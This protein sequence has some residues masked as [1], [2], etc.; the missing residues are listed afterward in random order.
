MKMRGL[1]ILSLPLLLA[2]F[3]FVV[4]APPANSA[5]NSG[6]VKVEEIITKHLASIGPA[7]SRVSSR[8]RIVVGKARMTIRS[9]GTSEAAGNAVLASQAEKSMITMK[10]AV[11]DYPYEKI[12]FDGYKVTA[13]ALRPGVYSTLG[14]FARTYSIILK[15]GLFGGTLSSAWPLLDLST[16]KVKLEYAGNKKI[17]SRPVIEVKYSPRGGSD[18]SI[19]LF[20][21]AETFQHVRTTYKRRIGAQIGPS[22]DQSAGQ[23]ES[24]YELTEDFS[25]FISENGLNLP[26]TYEIHYRYLSSESRYCDWMLTLQSF[27]FDKP[28]DVK[29]F[30]VANN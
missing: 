10:F 5:S 19:S 15:E 7:E 4:L 12:G 17:E 30:N 1:L 29:D 9:R 21:D 23:N 13:Y 3:G 20:F 26:H 2:G 11:P 6:D 25:N 22:V 14:D 8:P 16:R 27:V 24:R 28:I 18:L